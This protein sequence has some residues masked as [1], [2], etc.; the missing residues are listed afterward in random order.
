MVHKWIFLVALLLSWP[1]EGATLSNLVTR[2]IDGDTIQVGYTRVRLAS[3]DAPEKAMPYGP[4]AKAFLED[5]ILH[6]TVTVSYTAKD[7]YG[8]IIGEVKIENKSVQAAM[9]EAGMAWIYTDYKF[10][11]KLVALERE[12]ILERRG[13]WASDKPQSPWDWR[14]LQRLQ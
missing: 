4:E 13:L 9:I 14:R 11:P 3:I 8:R 7:R 2:V 12:A 5:L 10:D 1:V 6:R